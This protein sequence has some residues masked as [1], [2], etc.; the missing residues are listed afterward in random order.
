[1][2]FRLPGPFGGEAELC[3][4]A[5][6]HLFAQPHAMALPAPSLSLLVVD[7]EA[8]VRGMLAEYFERHG[9]HV[10]VA[11][12]APEAR[13]RLAQQPADLAI[14]DINMPGEDGLSL[15]RGLRDSHPT[16]PVVML[17]ANGD[18]VDRV[19]GLEIGA[20]DY[21]AKPCELRELLARVRAVLRRAQAP[22]AA[23]AAGPAAAPDTPQPAAE[24]EPPRQV[25]FGDCWLDLDAREL[26]A[27]DGRT[28]EI[29]AAEF[30]LLALFARHPNRPLSRDQ[31]MDLAHGRTWDAFDRSVDLRIMRLRRKIERNPDKPEVLKTVRNVG[32]VFVASAPR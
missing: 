16:M 25:A 27:A 32:Y 21:L 5:G 3:R 2:L 14:L 28:L 15:L 7:D 22:R 30:D 10:A 20:D 9:F 29:T 6:Y 23:A 13:Q 4:T 31:I 8:E 12:S 24:P 1:M 17:T 26:R 19:V 11:A 18:L